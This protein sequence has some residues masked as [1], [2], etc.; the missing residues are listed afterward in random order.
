MAKVAAISP[1]PV[2]TAPM[3]MTILG[4]QRSI[5]KPIAGVA[6]VET[7]KPMEN[8][9]AMVARLQPNSFRIGGNR[10][11]NAVRVLTPMPMVTKAIATTTQP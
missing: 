8:V 4:P 9:A 7:I 3:G 1:K 2:S 6:R 11:E 10:S 5:I